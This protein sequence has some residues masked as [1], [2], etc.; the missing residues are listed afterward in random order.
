[1]N[2]VKAN[3]GPRMENTRLR[4]P[5]YLQSPHSRPTQVMFLAATNQSLSPQPSHPEAEYAEAIGV[6]RYRVVVEVALYD[7]FEPLSGLRDRFVQALTELLFDFSQLRPQALAYRMALHCK[8]PVPIFPADVRESQKIE[9]FGLS[10]SSLF[11]V[12]FSESPE[13]NPARFVWV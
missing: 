11:P 5:S 6:A 10:F 2:G 7:R 13:L 1:M 8:V 9:R 3:A 4:E 12:L